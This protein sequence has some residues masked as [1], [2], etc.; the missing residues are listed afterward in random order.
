MMQYGNLERV[1][2]TGGRFKKRT[3][4]KMTVIFITALLFLQCKSGTEKNGAGE[5]AEIDVTMDYPRK[6]LYLQDIA[7]VEYIPFETNDNALMSRSAKIF[8]VS[9]DYIIAANIVEG[10][11]FV[12][13]GNGKWKHSFN[14]KGQGS[15]EYIYLNSIAFDEKA[16]EIFVCEWFSSN[17]KILVYGENG[18]YN[19]T[20][21]C[22]P[23]FWPNLYNFDD[24]TLFVY[25]D[26]GIFNMEGYSNRPYLFMSKKDGSFTDSLNIHLPVRLSNTSV[27][28]GEE[29][30]QPMTYS[31]SMRISY[32]RSYGKNFLIADWSADTIFRLTPQ[33]EL[34]PMIVRKP[35][36][37]STDPKIL[38]S[39]FL[40]TDKFILLGVH[41]MD[42]NA[43]KNGEEI[44]QKQ[45]MYDFGTGEIN[46]YRLKNK[47]IPSSTN[48][49]IMD[50]ITPENTGITMYN[51]AFLFDLDGKGE[52]KGDLKELL[53]TLNEDTNP[54]LVKIKF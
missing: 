46:V 18:E 15:E 30:G 8:Y 21:P 23:D 16:K 43:L 17:P 12:F 39:N 5:L 6:E 1:T 48:V 40:V 34:Q 45:L 41:K 35:P 29:N 22:P 14:H 37:Q 52:A 33:K 38:L 28:H 53:N 31:R 49:T 50:A 54:V 7:K 42:Y 51:A 24:E 47:D 44:S 9:D 36:M 3:G 25:D 27:W 19:R 10:D 13:D 2:E 4:L 20:L 26:Y 11:V 32:N